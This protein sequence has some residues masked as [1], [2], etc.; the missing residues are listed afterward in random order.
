MGL[1]WHHWQNFP[2]DVVA[3]V[4]VSEVGELGIVSV[5]S[6]S[7]SISVVMPVTAA[8]LAVLAGNCRSKRVAGFTVID[9]CI[10]CFHYPFKTLGSCL[11]II[12]CS[13]SIH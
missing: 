5:P 4:F 6:V 11:V 1:F 9:V 7:P 12:A 3:S 2:G 8:T 13:L 10:I